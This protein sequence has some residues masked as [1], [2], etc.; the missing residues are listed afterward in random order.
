MIRVSYLFSCAAPLLLAAC[1]E[2]TTVGGTQD[3]GASSGGSSSSGAGASSSGGSSGSSG[4]S[5]SSS[6]GSSGSSTANVTVVINEVATDNDFVELLNVGDVAVDL[7][8]FVLV[9]LNADTN[10]HKPADDKDSLVFATGTA[11]QPGA[12]LTIKADAEA[13]SN[14]R[15]PCFED[16]AAGPGTCPSA[17]FGLSKDKADAVFLLTPDGAVVARVDLNLP[18]AP[19]LATTESWCRTPT[20]S[21][22]FAVCA[23]RSAGRANP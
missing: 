21:G 16:D 8:G 15:T 22:H 18:P 6:G 9:D 19:P 1:A 14:E 11:L 5:S 10:D 4:N 13:S 17:G 3:A 12:Y 20:G 2:T 7:T 23:T